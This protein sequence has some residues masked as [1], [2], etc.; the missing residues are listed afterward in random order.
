MYNILRIIYSLKIHLFSGKTMMI[1]IKI[2]LKRYSIHYGLSKVM[3]KI[4]KLINKARV[5]IFCL[6][7][8]FLAEIL[9]QT[10]KRRVIY[11]MKLIFNRITI[12]YQ[13]SY[14]TSILIM[15]V[16][17]CIRIYFSDCYQTKLISNRF[18]LLG[19]KTHFSS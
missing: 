8:F 9:T 4:F 7:L 12:V 2:H 6:I 17:K 13:I 19:L 10:R 11:E 16:L 14:V 5:N 18:R 15:I 1:L 3:K